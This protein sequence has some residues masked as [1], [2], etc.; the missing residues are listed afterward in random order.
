MSTT[1][2]FPWNS[3]SRGANALASGLKINRILRE[4]SKFRGAG[5]KTVINW[6][7][8]TIDNPE[9][10]KCRVINPPEK[11]AAASDKLQ[12]FKNMT[13]DGGPRI[14][15]WTTEPLKALTWY[16]EDKEVVIRRVLSGHSGKGIDFFS[17]YDHD[18]EKAFNA[19]LF[20]QYVKKKDE[21][22]VHIVGNEVIDVQQKRL[23]LTDDN[24]NEIDKGKVDFRVRNLANGFIFARE[25]VNPP[26][27]VIEQALLAMELSGLDFGAV[28][29]LYNDSQEKAYVLEINTAPGIEG[30]TATNWVSAMRKYL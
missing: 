4:G 24:G 22:R 25:N 2:I 21:Y 14:P 29:V 8:S 7:A 28:D 1:K 5:S 27:D 19:P 23:R 3:K 16:K 30:T 11:V 10:M 12:F 18:I 20:T 15:K 9:I 17:E 13:K 6:G 26:E